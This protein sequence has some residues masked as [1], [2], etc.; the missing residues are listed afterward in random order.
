M[1]MIKYRCRTVEPDIS[2][3]RMVEQRNPEIAAQEFFFVFDNLPCVKY[4]NT[5]YAVVEVQDQIFAVV[6]NQRSNLYGKKKYTLD[7]VKSE[8]NCNDEFVYEKTHE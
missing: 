8:L 6:N 5:N 7:A 2:D 3:W 1:L 4:K